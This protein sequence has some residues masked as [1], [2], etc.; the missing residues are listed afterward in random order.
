MTTTVELG[1]LLRPGDPGYDE[2]RQVWNG[3]VDRR[4]AFIA[5]CRTTAEVAAAV[6]FAT[7]SGLEIAVR[8]GGHSIPGLS[9][10]EGG[11]MI[12]L[13][14]MKGLE[15]DPEQRIA[16]ARPGL[17][18]GEYDAGTQ[19]FGLASPGGEISHT[20]VAGLTLGGGIGWLSRRFGLA[21]D[22]LVGATLVLAD[23]SVLEVDE[24]REPELLWGLR[25][26]GGN[27]GIATELR[28]ALRE[29]PALHAGLALW[30]AEDAVE[31]LERY[32]AAT[33]AAPLELSLVAAQVVAPPA[34]FVPAE[35]QLRPAV[36][37]AAV[38]VG[39]PDAGERH[40]AAL[41]AGAS[42]DTFGR[43][44]YPEIQQWFDEGSPHGRRYHCRSEWL[45]PLDEA[46]SE[47]LAGA[48]WASTSPFNQVLVR[49]L[50]GAIADVAPD[51]TA[52]RFRAAT[53]M[54][55]VASGWDEGAG[56]EHVAWTRETWSSLRRWSCGGSYVNH[57]AA[58]EGAD[59]VR[60]AYGESTWRRLVDL[61]RRVDPD[62]VFHLNQNVDP[63]PSAAS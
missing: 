41:R 11:L 14:A 22:H 6:R 25:G 32:R 38:W 48:G 28:F 55:T 36:A 40:C 51:A 44:P 12:D 15:V 63:R 46:A 13:S 24:D 7:G 4:P 53:H 49:H 21:C 61:K 34:P 50:G 9:V 47:V 58:D 10:C 37:L 3:A 2:A 20:G 26:G 62:N 27:F 43:Q 23:G 54:L 42:A 1:E 16:R 30:P 45:G 18:W 56:D 33:E 59:R 52:F 31:V 29:V 60:E 57:L 5:R 8:S 39:D 35:L 19:R 17:L